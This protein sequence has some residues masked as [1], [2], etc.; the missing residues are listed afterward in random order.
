MSFPDDASAIQAMFIFVF[1][2]LNSLILSR[3]S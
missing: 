1:L 3:F 2:R